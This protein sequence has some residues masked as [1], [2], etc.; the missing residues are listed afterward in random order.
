MAVCETCGVAR[1][2]KVRLY[3]APFAGPAVNVMCAP[4]KERECICLC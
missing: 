4:R 3:S 1:A 2:F